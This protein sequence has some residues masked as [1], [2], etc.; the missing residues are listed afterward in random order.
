L[1]PAGHCEVSDALDHR[2]VLS[3]SDGPAARADEVLSYE[4]IGCNALIFNI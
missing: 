4:K 3:I 1:V 2:L